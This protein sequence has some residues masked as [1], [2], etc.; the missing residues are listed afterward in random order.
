MTAIRPAWIARISK[1]GD[2]EAT[3][4]SAEDHAKKSLSFIYYNE[5]KRLSNL[6]F[7]Y[8]VIHKVRA[9]SF[10]RTAH[11]RFGAGQ[12]SEHPQF[13]MRRGA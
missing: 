7:L 3:D 12:L 2:H 8:A 4:N 1:S 10:S 13:S 9:E 11:I 5:L 6:I